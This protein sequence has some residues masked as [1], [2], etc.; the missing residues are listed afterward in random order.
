MSDEDIAAAY[1]DGTILYM[2]NIPVSLRETYKDEA[3]V[4]D[5]LSTAV[6]YFNQNAEIEGEYIFAIK[7]VRQALSMAIDREAIADMIVFAEAASGLV[8]TGVFDT[9]SAKTLFRDVATT[10]YK[11]LTNNMTE[12]K[13]ILDSA[14]IDP[15]DYEFS[16]TVAAYDEVKVM[17]AKKIVEAWCELGFDVEL[18]M[19]GTVANNDYYKPTDSVPTDICD[20]LYFEDLRDGKFEVILLDLVA[21]SA[22]SFSVLAPFALAFSGSAMDMSVADSY[23]LTPHITGYNSEEYNALIEKIYNEKTIANRSADLHKAEDILME[24]MPV[25]PIVFNK[26]AYMVNDGLKMNNNSLSDK[27]LTSYY[28]AETLKNISVKNFDAYVAQVASFIESKFD[29]YKQDSLSYFG[30]EAYSALTFEEFKNESSNYAYFFKER[31][32]K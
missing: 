24:D 17:I 9:N 18:N 13:A 7:E 14:D 23:D 22:D 11:Y 1:E 5:A 31:A 2:G 8:A 15:E 4:K 16:L 29:T 20:D 26:V 32:E 28:G 3:I 6:C 30:S 27:K 10:E 12:A 21:P 25:M 19:R